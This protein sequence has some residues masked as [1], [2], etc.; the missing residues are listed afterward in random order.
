MSNLEN[1]KQYVY[2]NKYLT[3]SIENERLKDLLQTAKADLDELEKENKEL[4]EDLNMLNWYLCDSGQWG[5]S[6]DDRVDRYC[7]E[8]TEYAIAYG[9]KYDII[10][11]E[12]EISCKEIAPPKYLGE[13]MTPTKYRDFRC[14]CCGASEEG[15]VQGCDDC[16]IFKVSSGMWWSKAGWAIKDD[17]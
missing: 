11:Q 10:R 1:S 13:R 5:D 16:E 2:P 7:R 14:E 12:D 15:Q 9:K 8:N 6:Q 3:Y 4:K 17:V